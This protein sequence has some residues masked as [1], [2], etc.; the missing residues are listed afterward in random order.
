MLTIVFYSNGYSFIGVSPLAYFAQIFD[1]ERPDSLKYYLMNKHDY[2]DDVSIDIKRSFKYGNKL[3]INFKL[4]RAGTCKE[5]N[6]T[7]ICSNK[8]LV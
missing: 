8:I 4:T 3:I 6:K 2:I 5:G 1:G 7:E